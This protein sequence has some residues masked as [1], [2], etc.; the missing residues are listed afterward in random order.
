MKRW[1]PY[2]V[3]ALLALLLAFN[4]ENAGVTE[5]ARDLSPDAAPDTWRV[6][7]HPPTPFGL[8][9]RLIYSLMIWLPMSMFWFFGMFM[10]QLIKRYQERQAQKKLAALDS[11]SLNR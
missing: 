7:N 10:T 6:I 3:I 9:E 1:I 8:G 4:I 11:L 5:Y 2:F